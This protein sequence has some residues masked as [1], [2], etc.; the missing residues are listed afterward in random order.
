MSPSKKNRKYFFEG[1]NTGLVSDRAPDERCRAFYK[2]RSGNGLYCS[3]VGNVV[4]PG[5]SPVSAFTAEISSSPPWRLL[6]ESIA[7]QGAMPGIQLATAWPNFTGMKRFVTHSSEIEMRRYREVAASA[8][9][10]DVKRVFAALEHGTELAIQ[11]G[12]RHIQLHA[13]HGYLFGLLI[14]TRLCRHAA[15]VGRGIGD[16]ARALKSNAIQ[17]SVRFSL[18]TGDRAYDTAGRQEFLDFVSTLPVDY[19]DV[20]SGFYNVDKRLIYPSDESMIED[21]WTE[22]LELASRHGGAQF[23]MSGRAARAPDVRL[24]PNVHIGLC[25]DLIANPNFL[26]DRK[27]GCINAMKCHYYSRGKTHITCGRWSAPT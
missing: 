20:S 19:M 1:V 24:L 8:S 7:S 16:W 11:A 5:G 2:Q 25:R 27:N 10:D 21:R 15:L 3:I 6:A 12:F 13:A 4:V 17:T 26:R 18:R 9:T 23:I 22:T 14:D